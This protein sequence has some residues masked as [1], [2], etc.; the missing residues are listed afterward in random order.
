MASADRDSSLSPQATACPACG[1]GRPGTSVHH[2]VRVFTQYQTASAIAAIAYAGAD[3]AGDPLWHRSGAASTAEYAQWCH[4]ACGMACLQMVLHHRDGHTPQLLDLCYACAGYGG[5]VRQPDGSIR[6]LI[7][8]PFAAYVRAEHGID[9][10]VHRQLS[11]A[12]LR[13]ELDRGCLVMASVHPEIRRPDRT[14]PGRGGHLV[15]VIG[16]DSSGLHFRNPSG[17]TPA[18]RSAV[19]P[20][21]VF[22]AFAAGRGIAL[23]LA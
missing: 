11:L 4:H 14:A 7:Y 16:H 6:G 15:L 19:L 23:R 20:A 12:G 21:G 5:Y 1:G 9:A 8:D 17:H 2:P 3:P 18:A 13:A 10:T 22:G